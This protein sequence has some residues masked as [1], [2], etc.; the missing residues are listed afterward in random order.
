MFETDFIAIYSFTFRF[1]FFVTTVH[2]PSFQGNLVVTVWLGFLLVVGCCGSSI[3]MTVIF[4]NKHLHT[5]ANFFVF[6]LCLSDLISAVVCSPLWIYRRTWGF[7]KWLWGD[8]MCKFY[9]VSD[10][11]TSYTTSLHIVLFAFLRTIAVRWPYVIVKITQQMVLCCL[12]L[13]W[14]VALTIASPLGLIMG[15]EFQRE[16]DEIGNN[17]PSCSIINR[18]NCCVD[19]YSLYFA[20]IDPSLFYFP[21]LVTIILSIVIAREIHSRKKWHCKFTDTK[22]HCQVWTSSIKELESAASKSNYHDDDEQSDGSVSHA[23][24]QSNRSTNK[25]A[26]VTRKQSKTD[27]IGLKKQSKMDQKGNDPNHVER[28]VFAQLTVIIIG[29]MISYVPFSIYLIWAS[30]VPPESKGY[31]VDYWFGVASY[32]CLR[33]GE[34]MNPF[35]YNLASTN[36]RKATKQFLRKLFRRNSL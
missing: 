3:T 27:R 15:V 9:W 10:F 28:T 21:E 19:E 16:N 29:F 31:A 20:V 11:T 35:L 12:T 25:T 23:Q 7:D 18:N 13:L 6:S 5:K 26:Q 17:W 2:H 22:K 24:Q 34:C 30:T 32:I 8:F 1:T 14:M 36:L 4:I 33:T